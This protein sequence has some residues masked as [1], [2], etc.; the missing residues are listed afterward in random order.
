M[1]SIVIPVYNRAYIIHRSLDSLLNQTYKDWECL[2]IDDYSSDN[3]KEIVD[4][5]IQSDNRFVYYMNERTKGAQGARNTGVLKA[6]GEW[7][8]MFDSDDYMLPTYLETVV[9]IAEKQKNKVICCYGQIIE[10]ETYQRK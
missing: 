7:V 8:V 10:E 5:Y 2:I 9:K 6:H 3:T 4:K 1:I